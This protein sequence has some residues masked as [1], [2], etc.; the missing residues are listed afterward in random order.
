[1]CQGAAPGQGGTRAESWLCVHPGPSLLALNCRG[2]SAWSPLELW[3]AL[4]SP[5]GSF[6]HLGA[7]ESRDR[8]AEPC[9]NWFAQA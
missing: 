5:G 4:H 6:Q 9:G 8:A 2:C 1:M 3:L 7:A